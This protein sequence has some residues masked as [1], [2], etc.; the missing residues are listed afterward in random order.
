M[1]LCSVVVPMAL[2]CFKGVRLLLYQSDG[3]D[4]LQHLETTVDFVNFLGAQLTEVMVK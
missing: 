2:N 4:T 1:F 3:D